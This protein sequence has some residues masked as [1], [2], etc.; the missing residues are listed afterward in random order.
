MKTQ[1]IKIFIIMFGNNSFISIKN[2]HLFENKKEQDKGKCQFQVFSKIFE[3]IFFFF[4]F[5]T[6]NVFLLSCIKLFDMYFYNFF[7]SLG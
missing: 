6:Q 5:E 1:Y 3:L 7:I 4:D 2:R